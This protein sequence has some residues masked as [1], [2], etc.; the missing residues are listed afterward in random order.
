[1]TTTLT[2]DSVPITTPRS[3]TLA[4][5]SPSCGSGR[6]GK[7][8]TADCE[9]FKSNCDNEN[10]QSKSK[11]LNNEVFTFSHEGQAGKLFGGPDVVL[12]HVCNAKI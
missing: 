2:R 6:I 3:R 4:T 5:V 12:K 10:F 8:S 9:T 7:H 1:M 11:V